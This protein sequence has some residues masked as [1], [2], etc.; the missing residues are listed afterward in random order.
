MLDLTVASDIYFETDFNWYEFASKA[1][2]YSNYSTVLANMKCGDLS[3]IN[4][5]LLIHIPK[6]GGETAEKIFD[7]EKTHELGRNQK[8]IRP[9]P[10]EMTI[11]IIRNPFD[12]LFSFFRFCQRGWMNARGI[13]QGK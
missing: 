8:E 4:R 7:I 3:H 10:N 13:L 6:T 2:L 12:R 1:K 5:T 11:T 9:D